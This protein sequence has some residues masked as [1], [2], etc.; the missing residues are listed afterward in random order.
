MKKKILLT[1]AIVSLFVCLL[2]ASASAEVITYKDTTMQFD[3]KSDGTAEFITANRT[4]CTEKE[5]IIPSIIEYGGNE[6][7]VTKLADRSIGYQDGNYSNKYVEYVYVPSTVTSFG[8]QLFRN[9]PNLKKIKIDASLT[10][11][12]GYIMAGNPN[13]EEVDLSGMANLTTISGYAAQA[14]SKLTTVKLPNT[15]ETIGDKAFQDCAVTYINFPSSLKS[16]GSNCFQNAD[17]AKVVIPKSVT[18]LSSAAFHM[19]NNLKTVVFANPDISGYSSSNSLI[20]VTLVFY[21]G[22]SADTVK[23]QFSK[24]KNFTAVS[25][26][27]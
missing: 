7:T 27:D 11:I 24:F 2:A 17:F 12:D 14:C 21:A 4:E 9:C 16:I 15:V 23:T 13:L 5:I 20:Y 18:T 6:Y 26:E 8:S 1:L 3:L 10:T 19:T 25:Y 22:E